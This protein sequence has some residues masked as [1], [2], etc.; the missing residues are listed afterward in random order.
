MIRFYRWFLIQGGK[1]KYQRQ[2]ELV[3]TGPPVTVCDIMLCTVRER[4]KPTDS[5]FKFEIVSPQNR[6]YILKAE[7]RVCEEQS[8][9]LKRRG[10][11]ILASMVNIIYDIIFP[12][13]KLPQPIIPTY[14]PT[15]F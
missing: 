2:E 10:Y 9:E 11:W 14:L 12:S 7:V 6:T 4:N 1:L 8:D 5:R 15:T 3:V 13:V